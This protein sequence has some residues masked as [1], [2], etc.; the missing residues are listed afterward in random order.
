M[1][2]K[3]KNK[4]WLKCESGFVIARLH[5]F[6]CDNWTLCERM[7]IPDEKTDCYYRIEFDSESKN[8]Y[9]QKD[10]VVHLMYM[11]RKYINEDPDLV[12]SL[13]NFAEELTEEHNDVLDIIETVFG[14]NF[15]GEVFDERGIN[16]RED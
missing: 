8:N 7:V 11:E 2:Q 13:W 16:D 6:P 3:I 12:F 10:V 15:D 9:P 14:I 5:N 1:I 4:K